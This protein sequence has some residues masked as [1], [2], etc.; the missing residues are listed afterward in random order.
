MAVIKT[1]GSILRT[2]EHFEGDATSK[3]RRDHASLSL[4]HLDSEFIYWLIIVKK[5]LGEAKN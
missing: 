5:I 4:R 3:V 1:L 2:L